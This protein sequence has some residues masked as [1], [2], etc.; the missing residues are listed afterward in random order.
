VPNG[1]PHDHPVTDTVV[2]GMHPFPPALEAM[3]R[4]LHALDP[5]VFDQLG[6]APFDWERGAHLEPAAELLRGL[7]ASHGDAE[8]RRRLISAYQQAT[9]PDPGAS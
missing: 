8:S 7:L 3:I 1:K 5:R 2:H 9:R 4:E 6:W